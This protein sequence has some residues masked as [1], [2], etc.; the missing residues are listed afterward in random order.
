M[1]EKLML[2]Y[3]Y[4][5]QA[6]QY[7]FYRLPKALIKDRRF[8]DI[9]S[10]SK[11]LYS[12][13]LDRM[14]LSLK[15]HWVDELNRVYII[16]TLK[17]VMIEFECSERKASSLMAELKRGGLIEKKRRGLGKADLVYVKNFIVPKD[18]SDFERNEEMEE[19]EVKDL[20]ERGIEE[21]VQ[22]SIVLQ[23]CEIGSA[24]V[25]D[26]KELSETMYNSMQPKSG[27]FLRLQSGKN[28]QDRS[29]KVVPVQSVEKSQN[30][31][32]KNFTDQNCHSMPNQTSNVLLG[33]KTDRNNINWNDT[34][35]YQSYQNTNMKKYE[36]IIKKNIEYDILVAACSDG[37]KDSID[38]I[39]KLILD[40]VNI[41]RNYVRISGQ[42]Y[43]YSVV[44]S[45]FLELNTTHI[46]YVLGCLDENTTE[47]HNIHAYLLTALYHAPATINHFYKTKVNHDLYG[48][49]TEIT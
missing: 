7:S 49:R 22:S 33:N 19:K 45:R 42:D 4:G 38:E 24:I 20:G 11:L 29:S 40:I 9:S 36:E 25:K 14:S 27:S 48:R 2:D 6:D 12:I 37:E 13:L 31:S 15:N 16:Y 18:Y 1:T 43:P 8:K 39:V 10:D 44:K 5:S 21:T 23:D 34:S 3:Y 30:Q 32:S 46:Q 28:L 41:P 26:N 47:I 17:E 35:I